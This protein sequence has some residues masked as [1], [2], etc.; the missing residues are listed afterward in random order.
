MIPDELWQRSATELADLIRT[1]QVTSV[2]VVQA[3]LARIATVN[4]KVNA[5]TVVLAEGALA[6]ADAADQA[7]AAGQPVGPLHGVPMTVKENIDL[8]GSATTQGVVAFA[9]QIPALDAPHIAQL[10]AAG[11]IP[12][13]RTNLP[14]FGMRWHTDNALRGAT[15]NPWDAARSPGGSSGGE[16]AALATGMTPLGMGNDLGGS[17]RVPAQACGI[18]ALRPT[19]G[20]VPWATSVGRPDLPMTIQM[21]GAQ[22]PMARH[23]G[24]LRL[25]LEAMSGAD[26]RDPWWTPAPLHGPAPEGPVRVAVTLDPAGQGVER[27]VARG[28]Q[29]AAE[30]L[31][32]AGYDVQ[33]V[34]PP[35]PAVTEGANLWGQLFATE[36]RMAVLPV[37]QRVASTSALTFLD[38][39]FSV[40]P[41]VGHTAYVMDF[42][43]R[44]RIARAWTQFQHEWPLVLGPVATIAPPLVGF[45]LGGPDNV[46]ALVR[47]HRLT[48]LV[49]LLGLPAVAVPVGVWDHLPQGVQ[50]IGPRYREDLCLDA[51]QALEDKLGVITPID[52]I[53]PIDPVRA[54]KL[55]AAGA[56]A[57]PAGDIRRR[58]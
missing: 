16:A 8:A 15:R 1:E 30:A 22:G 42:A 29:R 5:V 52:P 19:L 11:V 18:T 39:F 9:S 6:A 20:R 36:L 48:L 25:A 45:D 47:A 53:D 32:G 26:P 13:G 12:I 50:I 23:V 41:P 58:R 4:P 14:D 3:H 43:A 46:F 33:E 37:M 35:P 54:S 55:A 28:V 38:D 17:L 10:K 7:L 49:N 40:V 57:S 34:D 2:E 24:D 56:S 21:F 27:A 31:A 44:N 51:A